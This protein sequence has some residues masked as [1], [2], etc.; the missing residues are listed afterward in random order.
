MI[1]YNDTLLSC[2][3]T[4]I[5]LGEI[6]AEAQVLQRVGVGRAVVPQRQGELPERHLLG[7]LRDCA[8][9]LGEHGVA[10][11]QRAEE[12]VRRRHVPRVLGAAEGGVQRLH[13]A[14]AQ[15]QAK[16][17]GPQRVQARVRGVHVEAAQA[18]TRHGREEGRGVVWCGGV[19]E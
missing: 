8:H 11:A 18:Q 10:H 7:E 4:L 12:L 5:D 17:A 15:V 3:V 6:H 2:A 9:S 13:V 19:S 14:G 1:Q 16:E